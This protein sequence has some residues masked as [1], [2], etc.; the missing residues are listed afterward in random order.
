[1]LHTKK[2]AYRDSNHKCMFWK[3]KSNLLTVEGIETWHHN[4]KY[5]ECIIKNGNKSSTSYSI[6][7]KGKSIAEFVCNQPFSHF[8]D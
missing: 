7:L 1:M 3:G 2:N 8:S 4:H 6:V 5:K